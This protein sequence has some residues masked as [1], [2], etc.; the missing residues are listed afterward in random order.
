MKFGV[1]RGKEEN[2]RNS[3]KRMLKLKPHM[4]VT[5]SQMREDPFSM[6]KTDYYFISTE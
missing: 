3:C 2:K 5:D 6:N 1:E 4:P